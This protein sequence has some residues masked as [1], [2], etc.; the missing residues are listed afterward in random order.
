MDAV[1]EELTAITDAER[2][3]LRQRD[4]RMQRTY[5]LSLVTGMAA[6]A[7]SLLMLALFPGIVLIIFLS[8][9]ILNRLGPIEHTR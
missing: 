8:V 1:E 6:G 5:R 7:I 4:Q 9:I 2:R 3:L